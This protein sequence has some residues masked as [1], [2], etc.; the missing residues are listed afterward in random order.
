[1]D[2]FLVINKPEDW[3]SFDVVAKIRNK[4]GV[5]KVGHTGTLDP[6]AT[7]VLVLC[8]GKATKLA[9]SIVEKDKEYEC[10]VTLGKTSTTDDQEGELTETPA[11]DYQ[12]PNEADIQN[13]L[14]FFDGEFEQM[15]PQFSAKKVNGKRAYKAARAGKTVELKPSLVT[16]HE[17]EVLSYEWPKLQ[18]RMRCG[19]GFYVRALARDIGVKLNTGGYLTMLKRTRVGQY[20][21]E[22]AVTIEEAEEKHVIPI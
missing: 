7:G 6:K 1:M 21:I 5:K 22:E 20:S 11:S 3:T 16:L 13:V 4:L 9:Q 15:P 8:L 10:E 17:L 14:T 18:L 19:K 2:G 12:V